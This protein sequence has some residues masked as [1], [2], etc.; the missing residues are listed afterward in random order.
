MKDVFEAVF[1]FDQNKKI[2][3]KII[4]INA[5][6]MNK[7]YIDDRNTTKKTN[8]NEFFLKALEM[9]ERTNE[10]QKQNKTVIEKGIKTLNKNKK[11]YKKRKIK[12][13]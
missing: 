12:K 7:N 5:K 9:V 3:K 6:I 4:F 10:N 1:V 8:K 2:E 11:I 13:K